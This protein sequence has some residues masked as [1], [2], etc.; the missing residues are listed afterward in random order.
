[1]S[2][3]PFAGNFF[4]SGMILCKS[5]SCKLLILDCYIAIVLRKYFCFVLEYIS[6]LDF[7]PLVNF[8]SSW[9]SWVVTLLWSMETILTS[10]P[11]LF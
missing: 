6:Q 2:E 5:Y 10:F 11:N 7:R 4:A 8:K 9:F 3:I 1:M